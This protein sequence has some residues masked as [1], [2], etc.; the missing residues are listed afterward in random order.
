MARLEAGSR[1]GGNFV[2]SEAGRAQQLLGAKHHDRLFVFVG[3]VRLAGRD[4]LGKRRTVFYG[5]RID[6]QVRRRHIERRAQTFLPAGLRL[7]GQSAHEVEA[8]IIR[9][10]AHGGHGFA[11]VRCAVRAS[12]GR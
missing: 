7:A 8:E 9:P 3:D 4:A 6:A 12:D 2:A 11:R 1:I 5:K 10:L